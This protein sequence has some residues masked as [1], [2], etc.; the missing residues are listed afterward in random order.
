[1]VLHAIVV[2]A[3]GIE[4]PVPQGRQGYGLLLSLQSIAPKMEEGGGV[5]PHWL[6]TSPR[7]SGPL[8]DH[9]AAP[10]SLADRTGVEPVQALT[11]AV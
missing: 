7:F 11:C 6:I 9:S 4:P 5:E 10:S 8:A 3:E 2:G 1:M